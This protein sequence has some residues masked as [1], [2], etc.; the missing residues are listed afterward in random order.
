MA[1]EER[2]AYS[3]A[4]PGT[5][6]LG[7]DGQ[8]IGTLDRVLDIPDLDLFDGIV[9]TTDAGTR[10]VDRDQVSHFTWTAVHCS[11]TAAQAA[12]LP[13]PDSAPTYRADPTQDGGSSIADRLKR[14]FRRAKWTREKDES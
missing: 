14:T 9:V 1:D 13:E 8:V 2:I 4:V 3:A 11:L 12:S 6:V 5:P 10:F 7:S